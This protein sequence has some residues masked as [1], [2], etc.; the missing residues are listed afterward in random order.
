MNGA[1]GFRLAP[2]GRR[3]DPESVPLQLVGGV[4]F[5]SLTAAAQSYGVPSS[6]VAEAFSDRVPVAAVVA[7]RRRRAG[8]VHGGT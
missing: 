1:D 3:S 6:W 4:T 2:R 8:G 7:A 5:R